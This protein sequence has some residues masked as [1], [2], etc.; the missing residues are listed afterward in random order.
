MPRPEPVPFFNCSTQNSRGSRIR[1]IDEL[2][3][4]VRSTINLLV[5]ANMYTG[6]GQVQ[7]A[8][9]RDYPDAFSFIR[10]NRLH[11]N[12][13]PAILGHQQLIQHVN[14][15]AWGY[16][17]ANPVLEIRGLIRNLGPIYNLPVALEL[18][19]VFEFHRFVKDAFVLEDESSVFRPSTQVV[20]DE[21]NACIC[22]K[23]HQAPTTNLRSLYRWWEAVFTRHMLIYFNDPCVSDSD[24]SFNSCDF[25]FSLLGPYGIRI[26]G[27]SKLIESVIK[28]LCPNNLSQASRSAELM[29]ERRVKEIHQKFADDVLTNRA[30][31][32][33]RHQKP[34]VALRKLARNCRNLHENLESWAKDNNLT[35]LPHY[36]DSLL[37]FADFLDG[38]ARKGPLKSILHLVLTYCN[39]E[40]FNPDIIPPK[41]LKGIVCSAGTDDAPAIHLVGEGAVEMEKGKSLA[42]VVNCFND[43]Y[44]AFVNTVTTESAGSQVPWQRLADLERRLSIG[45]GKTLL[46]FLADASTEGSEGSKPKC[47][48]IGGQLRET[49]PQAQQL[50]EA[51]PQTSE[52]KT[53][54]VSRVWGFI[55]HLTYLT[56]RS[57]EALMSV[58]MENL[59]IPRSPSVLQAIQCILTDACISP[60]KCH[61]LIHP[62]EWSFLSTRT[63]CTQLPPAL[64][65]RRTVV[66]RLLASCPVLE[67]PEN[68][69]LWSLC[70]A[71]LASHWGPFDEF[72]ADVTADVEICEK[73]NLAV[74]KVAGNGYV[75]LS[76]SG[77]PGD[78]DTSLSE[79]A[80]A[81]NAEAG[82]IAARELCD[83][84]IGSTLF[85]NRSILP[86]D[87]INI[88]GAKLRSIPLQDVWHHF[89]R[90]ILLATPLSLLGVLFSKILLPALAGIFVALEEGGGLEHL[91]RSVTESY[92]RDR[93]VT[94]IGVVGGQLGWSQW[95]DVFK[96]HRLLSPEHMDCVQSRRSTKSIGSYSLERPHETPLPSAQ[97]LMLDVTEP[98]SQD[99]AEFKPLSVESS[100]TDEEKTDCREFIEN[101][102]RTEF[103]LGI[104]LDPKASSL[105]RR[106]EGRLCRSLDHLSRELYG[107][108][109]HFIL[110]LIQNADDNVYTPNVT[111][112]VHFSLSPAVLTVGNNEAAGFSTADISALCDIGLST[113]IGHR[114]DKIGR[115][116]IGFKSVFSVSDAP[117]VHSNGFH[118]RFR[119]S[120]RS[121]GTLTSLLTP[122]WIASASCGLEEWRTLFRLPLRPAAQ[123]FSADAESILTFAR[124]LITHHLLLFLRRIDC[125]AFKTSNLPTNLDFQLERKSRLILALGGPN[126]SFLR[127]FTITEVCN[128][129]RQTSKWLLLRYR[130]SVAVERLKRLFRCSSELETIPR[131]SDIEIAIPLSNKNQLPTFPVYAFLPIRSTEFQF[132]LNADFDLTS[133]REDVDGSSVWNQYLVNQIPAVFESLINCVTKMSNFDE[134]PL[135]QC[136]ILGRILE[137]LP[138]KNRVSASVMGLFD[139]L[140]EKIR[141]KLSNIPWLPVLNE[142]KFSLP[143]K[144]LLSSPNSPQINDPVL[145]DKYLFRLLIDRLGM[146]ELEQTFLVPPRTTNHDEV[147][148][149]SIASFEQRMEKLSCLGARRISADIL[150]ELASTLSPE[151]LSRPCVLYALLANIDSCLRSSPHQQ[152]HYTFLKDR[153]AW[154]RRCL[155]NLRSLR[156]F[157]LLD[158]RLVSLEEIGDGMANSNGLLR[159]RNGLM[160]P[161]KPPSSEKDRL[162]NVYDDYLQLLSRLGPLLSPSSIYPTHCTFLELPRLL[163]APEDGMGIIVANSFLDV[164][165][166]WVV[167][168][169]PDFDPESTQDADWFIAAAQLIVLADHLEE[170]LI[171][172][173]PI[174]CETA[175]SLKLFNPSADV[176]FLS[177][178]LLKH[179]P[180]TEEYEIM[181]LCV[182]TM[183]KTESD[184]EEGDPI[185]FVSSNYFTSCGP[186]LELN[187]PK[188]CSKWQSLFLIAGLS[189]IQTLHPRKYGLSVAS[190]HLPLL[191]STHVLKLSPALVCLT[192]QGG[193]VIEDWTCPGLENLVLPWIERTTERFGLIE[194]VKVV[195]EKLAK[196][197]SRNWSQ[198]FEKYTLA[199]ANKGDGDN[200]MSE[201]KGEDRRVVLGASSWLQALRTRKWLVLTCP[202]DADNRSGCLLE[203]VAATR[204]Q[205]SAGAA[206]DFVAT[207]PIYTPTVFTEGMGANI[208]LPLFAPFCPLW[209]C[210]ETSEDPL[211]PGLIAALGVK[212]ILDESTFQHLMDHLSKDPCNLPSTLTVATMLQVY[213][214]A[215]RVLGDT[216]PDLLRHI[217][218]SALLVPCMAAHT[219]CKKRQKL[220]DD[221]DL[222]RQGES[223]T[224]NC[225][226]CV[227]QTKSQ[228]Q[229]RHSAC[230]VSYHLVPAHRTC[231][232]ELRLLPPGVVRVVQNDMEPE[233]D[234]DD[235]CVRVPVPSVNPISVTT[236]CYSAFDRRVPL[237]DIYGPEWKNFFC[238]VLGVP[239]TSS[240]GEVLSQRPFP[241]SSPLD[242]NRC[243]WRA[244]QEAFG[245]RL[246]A[247]YTLI[248]RCFVAHS[249]TTSVTTEEGDSFLT[250]LCNFPLLYDMTGAWRVPNQVTSLSTSSADTGL[251]FA[252]SA[253]DLA[254]MLPPACLLGHS[255]EIL[256]GDT[257]LSTPERQ[258]APMSN[259]HSLLLNVLRLPVLEKSVIESVKLSE[260]QCI[261][262]DDGSLL[263]FAV[264][265]L[266]LNHLVKIFRRLTLAW[267]SSTIAH[268]HSADAAAAFTTDTSSDGTLEAFLLPNL[269]VKLT[270]VRLTDRPSDSLKEWTSFDVVCR[271]WRGKLYV[272]KRFEA[273][274]A[275]GDDDD[276]TALPLCG[277]HKS[278]YN[279]VLTEL[280]RAVFPTNHSAQ[281]SLLHF[282]RGLMSLRASL[283]SS[284][285]AREDVTRQLRAYLLSH[286]IPRGSRYLVDLLHRLVPEVSSP[287]SHAIISTP[288][289]S[290]SL[291][292]VVNMA[293][294]PL[295][296]NRQEHSSVGYSTRFQTPIFA[297]LASEHVSGSS[298]PAPSV[299]SV[300]LN[301]FAYDH[302]TCSTNLE[303]ILSH[304]THSSSSKMNIGRLG[305]Q[306]VYEIYLDRMRRI[307]DFTFPSGHPFLGSGRLVE[308]R[309]VNGDG[310][311][312]LPYDL[313]V[314]LEVN[315]S[316]PAAR[317]ELSAEVR[318][319]IIQQ[320]T[321]SPN[322]LL[323]GPIY[324]EV[325]STG[326]VEERGEDE[327]RLELFE[328]SLA[329]AAFARTSGWRYHLVRVRWSRSASGDTGFPLQ[330]RIAHIPNLSRAFTDDSAHHRLYIGLRR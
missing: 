220:V 42:D 271:F 218:S 5:S 236:P 30:I 246:A 228:C 208:P 109:G 219:A 136:E 287:P 142:A 126:P 93:I 290:D 150:I 159:H 255:L 257:D 214:L 88:V 100:A 149:D 213:D 253:G 203:L 107:Q 38:F 19:D 68:W 99:T 291:I 278:I 125:I 239:L 249:G 309:W 78:L 175:R 7:S 32:E 172:R 326:V 153:E 85:V 195:C 14:A 35:W 80:S 71:S 200:R 311:S 33:L 57:G 139:C 114:E 8:L 314:F 270:L 3:E 161:P 166:H 190:D 261:P 95:I 302:L 1:S 215:L 305:E 288:L 160:I 224:N 134:I 59:N 242:A 26:K 267:L 201:M 151:E 197:L 34:K 259:S 143:N 330:P 299:A 194:S 116:G 191:P 73:Y 280:A 256:G 18:C 46:T 285:L 40:A 312:C 52:E 145:P 296:Q 108:Q 276:G 137:C 45:S 185:M 154:Q 211:A 6:V 56:E 162:K 269:V 77:S 277:A 124:Q 86:T 230:T 316:M 235:D 104:D 324:V 179:V 315:G 103:G 112:S 250:T 216:R 17:V 264:P 173:L 289:N 96:T 325:K 232:E 286:C 183:T 127:L 152:Y 140:G 223:A 212:Q 268:H 48:C 83:L 22:K 209:Q 74:I 319:S 43:F 132:L 84:L 251:L 81:V 317:T 303:S 118:V 318:S 82:C 308:V 31:A 66:L 55:R 237:C 244:A 174:V 258:S 87:C 24:E 182:E 329:E 294:R 36:L 44:E 292:S 41:L 70:P 144:V 76:V 187:G 58:A 164:I 231:W 158:G 198:S 90:R 27:F 53:T 313:I 135:S 281:V 265:S 306:T 128:G 146:C 47:L 65:T 180:D 199:I 262:D 272:D 202:I 210:S 163:T 247:W 300:R 115:K 130:V 12:N 298:V 157:P 310:E 207:P 25:Q 98:S 320:S 283:L 15:I 29:I 122:E 167:S 301:V 221:M 206:I 10:N 105:I 243:N 37:S 75:R 28:A 279:V 229:K 20:M 328:I 110:E 91:L 89:I 225:L 50:T 234:E 121:D 307:H 39:S 273:D 177:P 111:P 117:E 13:I 170:V 62:Q 63:V 193:T 120:Q 2:N 49:Q 16:A 119:R 123:G 171:S 240:L 94:G 233:E 217:F 51:A 184:E 260:S 61:F 248:G 252:W 176:A 304:S 101:L 293:P 102:R 64:F 192:G 97:T 186:S 241:P 297:A 148:I 275:T 155:R 23:R 254:A 245:R 282:A 322:L 54:N 188:A 222:G 79:C 168:R 274:F 113:K 21:L 189:T 196:L 169:Q 227:L 323:V 11:P 205:K 295:S 321:T 69:S 284:S 263:R 92:E 133:S 327:Q 67:D 4:A 147:V 238:K 72:L 204:N 181:S 106:L 9:F 266:P 178:A 141:E 226:F 165:N 138:L 156:L 129:C 60:N 131:Q